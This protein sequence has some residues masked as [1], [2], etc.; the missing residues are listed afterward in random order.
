MDYTINLE[1]TRKKF[2]DITNSNYLEYLDNQ[3]C[4]NKNNK[5]VLDKLVQ[6]KEEI[7]N[8]M[9]E[10]ETTAIDE[11]ESSSKMEDLCKLIYQKPWNRLNKDQKF[12]RLFTFIS[13]IVDDSTR[14][15]EVYQVVKDLYINKKIVPKN[16]QYDKEVGLIV[17][18]DKLEINE[19][20]EVVYKGVIVN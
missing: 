1:E 8:S 20:F 14:V 17:S 3:V 16:V 10:K 2:I 5:E 7:L 19:E 9:K 18:I 4:I 11:V 12:D 6:K 15:K 13:K